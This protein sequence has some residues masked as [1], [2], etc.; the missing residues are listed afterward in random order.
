MDG[1]GNDVLLSDAAKYPD[2]QAC[3]DS[4]S[5]R[6]ATCKKIVSDTISAFER[7]QARAVEAGIGDIVYFFYPNVP[8]GT[9][10]GGSEP[11]EVAAYALPMWRAACEG[12]A[13]RHPGKLACHFVDMVPVFE[14]HPDWFAP[15]D[16][17]PNS[18]GSAAMAKAIIAKMKEA[19]VW[20]PAGS[21]CCMTR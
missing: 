2:G 9:L 16:I 10:I 12:A 21:G 4:G 18:L 8:A 6:L 13:A 15:T 1:G 20:Q 17:H 11:N 3:K 19:C 14:G 7:L 5:S